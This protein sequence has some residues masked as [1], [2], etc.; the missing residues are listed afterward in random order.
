VK[1][2][3]KLEYQMKQR[4]KE[5]ILNEEVDFGCG[6]ISTGSTL[7]DLAISGG[8]VEGGGLPA[9]ILVEIFGPESSGKTVILSEIAGNIQRS[10]GQVMFFDPE[11]RLNVQFARLFGLKIEEGIYKQPDTVPEVFQSVREWVPDNDKV[12][13]GIMTDSLAALST[14]LEMENDEGDKM[15]TRR[16]KEFSEQLRKTCRLLKS[17]KYLMVCSNQIRQNIDAGP[18]GQKYVAPGGNS[19]GFY[20]SVRLR[21]K[22]IEKIKQTKEVYNVKVN[23]VVGVEIEVEVVKNSVWKPY[24]VAPLTIIF[25]YGIDDTR[26]NLQFL[27]TYSSG[28]TYVVNGKNLGNSLEK[29]IFKVEEEG[30]QKELKSEVIKVWNEIENQFGSKRIKKFD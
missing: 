15:G 28:N 1:R 22:I 11:A 29:A 13:N 18:W 8:V 30:L 4:Q 6:V 25:D 23:R 26:Q 21:T 14:E 9:G 16:A 17:K 5:D 20:S 10:G 7:L 3:S 27:K 2:L 24:R 19:I 12:I